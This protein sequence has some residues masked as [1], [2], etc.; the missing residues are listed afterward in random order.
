MM[1]AGS[2]PL[3]SERLIYRCSDSCHGRKVGDS[4]VRK[5][6]SILRLSCGQYRHYRGDGSMT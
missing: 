5:E 4:A 2:S 3:W 6:V 1:P